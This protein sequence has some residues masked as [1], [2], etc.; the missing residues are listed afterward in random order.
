MKTSTTSNLLTENTHRI[1]LHQQKVILR[2][3]LSKSLTKINLNITRA[4]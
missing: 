2:E 3:I 4:F 1:Y